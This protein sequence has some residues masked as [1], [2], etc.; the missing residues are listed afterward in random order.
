MAL[1]DG[2]AVGVILTEFEVE[3]VF[4]VNSKEPT[5]MQSMQPKTAMTSL[6]RATQNTCFIQLRLCYARGLSE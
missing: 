4:E 5:S 1:P 6:C 3:P 2:E